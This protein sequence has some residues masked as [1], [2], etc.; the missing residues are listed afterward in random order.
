MMTIESISD[1]IDETIKWRNFD[2]IIKTRVPLY[3]VSIEQK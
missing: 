2:F 3:I 1:N